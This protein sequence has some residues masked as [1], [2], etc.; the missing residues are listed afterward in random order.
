MFAYPFNRDCR[1]LFAQFY[2][3]CCCVAKLWTLLP[4]RV[5]SNKP[6]AAVFFFANTSKL[7]NCLGSE[8]SYDV[9]NPKCIHRC[10]VS[11]SGNVKGKGRNAATVVLG[12]RQLQRPKRNDCGVRVWATPKAETQELWCFGPGFSASHTSNYRL[13]QGPLWTQLQH[14]QRTFFIPNA[15]RN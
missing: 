4:L 7:A 15:A 13:S 10:C 5:G 11:G 6:S 12:C 9:G 8:S 3:S 14:F 1:L 2:L